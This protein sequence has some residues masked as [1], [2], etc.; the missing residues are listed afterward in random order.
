MSRKFI[1]DDK[2]IYNKVLP[3]IEGDFSDPS[4]ADKVIVVISKKVFSSDY[5][6]IL[7]ER[8]YADNLACVTENALFSAY[9]ST[10]FYSSK[11]TTEKEYRDFCDELYVKLYR[12]ICYLYRVNEKSG[13]VPH[14]DFIENHIKYYHNNSYDSTNHFDLEMLIESLVPVML[15]NVKSE[16]FT[17]IA[18][19]T[20]LYDFTESA[21]AYKELSSFFYSVIEDLIDIIEKSTQEIIV[22]QTKD[23]SG[24]EKVNQQISQNNSPSTYTVGM[25]IPAGTH[26]FSSISQTTPA[27][28]IVRYPNGRE[29]KFYFEHKK[30]VRLKPG[31]KVELK[32]CKIINLMHNTKVNHIQLPTV[33]KVA[34][35]ILIVVIAIVSI[36]NLSKSNTESETTSPTTTQPVTF[37]ISEPRSGYILE[38]KEY[39]NESELTIHA[40]GGE[41]CVVKLKTRSGVT[42]LSFYVR[43]GDTVTIGVPCEKLYVYFA[44]GDTWYGRYNLF[45]EYTSY[46]KDSTICNFEKYTMS[47]TLYPVSDGNFSETPI[48]ADEF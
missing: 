44:S 13:S 25:D 11:T 21:N 19:T 40:S 48:N 43:A 47:Y 7:S 38:G 14:P 24:S 8:I 35:A 30:S 42:R 20:S 31:T 6:Y 45:G 4:L 3:I 23:D 16:E 10:V 46:S 2:W 33:L 28:L 32:N 12:F 41:S 18:G 27:L 17:A 36:V 37:Q 5:F 15:G 1:P 29:K 39:F 9:L 22:T 26:F 34:F